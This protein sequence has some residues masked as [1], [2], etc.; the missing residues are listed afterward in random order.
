MSRPSSFASPTELDLGDFRTLGVLI[1]FLDSCFGW[2]TD[3]MAA[4]YERLGRVEA[5]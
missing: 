4:P 2:L 3:R 5:V 1:V